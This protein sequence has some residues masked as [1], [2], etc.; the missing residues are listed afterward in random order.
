MAE[1]V[2]ELALAEAVA[3]VPDE[4]EVPAVST[5]EV[6]FPETVVSEPEPVFGDTPLSALERLSIPG[7]LSPQI[8]RRDHL[9]TAAWAASFA[10]LAGLGVAGYTERDQLM[11]QW[12]ASKRV[13]ATLGLVPLDGH[14]GDRT[15]TDGK[16]G[17]A[18][19]P[20]ETQPR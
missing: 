11:R 4:A 14:V 16:D 18:P 7:D 9:L 2:E 12:P 3:D 13:Y 8:R 1:P 15:G 5:P 10:I 17:T 20:A 6:P 19:R